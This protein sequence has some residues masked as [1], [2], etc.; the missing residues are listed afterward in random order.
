MT[1][2]SNSESHAGASGLA[3]IARDA[4]GEWW[5]WLTAL[6]A[7]ALAAYAFVAGANMPNGYA[8]FFGML[9]AFVALYGFHDMQTTPDLA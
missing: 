3:T 5:L 1:S 2:E 7:V 4:L 6:G 9:G 8:P